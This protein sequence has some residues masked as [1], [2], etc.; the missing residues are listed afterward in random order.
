MNGHFSKADMALAGMSNLHRNHILALAAI[1]SSFPKGSINREA[2][3]NNLHT[4]PLFEGVLQ[5]D[6]A[7]RA[8]VA[9]LVDLILGQS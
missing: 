3:Q 5:S 9:K 4:L 8:E 2:L 7:V 1:V 6:A